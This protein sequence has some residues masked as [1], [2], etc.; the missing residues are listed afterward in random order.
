MG[1]RHGRIRRVR[2]K[3]YLITFQCLQGGNFDCLRRLYGQAA[4]FT[5]EAE[6]GDGVAVTARRQQIAGITLGRNQL[7]R[8]VPHGQLCPFRHAAEADGIQSLSFK[9]L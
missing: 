1:Q 9:I 6:F 8:A 3:A 4:R 7:L 2:L 5:A